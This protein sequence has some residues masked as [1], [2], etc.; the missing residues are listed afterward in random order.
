MKRGRSNNKLLLVCIFFIAF[1]GKTF[2]QCTSADSVF[3]SEFHYDNTGS[4]VNE[5]VEITGPA[6]T[7]LGCYRIIL[8]NGDNGQFYFTQTLSGFIDDEGCGYGSVP[9]FISGIQNGDPDGIVLYNSCSNTVIQF[10]SY[11]GTFTAVNGPASG[12]TSTDIG[13]YEGNTTPI[14]YSLQLTGTGRCYSDIV[15]TGGWV[16]P[17]TNS[18]GT[19]N[20]GLNMCLAPSSPDTLKFYL[21]STCIK[22]NKAA[23]ILVCAETYGGSTVTSY[24]GTITI[25]KISGP[26]SISG[27]L[28]Q[29]AVN[30][31]ATFSITFDQPGTY[32]LSASDGTLTGRSDNIVVEVPST[33]PKFTSILVNACGGSGT[34]EGINEYVTIQ[35]GVSDLNVN[36]I[37]ICFPNGGCFC[38]SG[39]GSQTWVSNPSFVA[40][41]NSTAGCPLFIDALS[42]GTIPAGATIV[43]FTGSSPTYNFDFSSRCGTG[44][45]YALFANNTNTSGR[46]LNYDPSCSTIRTLTAQ[47]GVCTDTVTYQPCQLSNTDGDMVL[48]DDA[49]NLTYTNYPGCDFILPVSEIKLFGYRENQLVHLYWQISQSLPLPSFFTIET[50]SS[51]STPP[52]PCSTI[53][54]IENQYDYDYQVFLPDA[55]PLYVRIKGKYLN[56]EVLYSNWIQLETNPNRLHLFPNPI[57]SRVSVAGPPFLKGTFLIATPTGEVLHGGSFES[58]SE[59]ENQ[60]NHILQS[61]N[62]GLYLLTLPESGLTYKLVKVR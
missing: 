40:Q 50:T 48:I 57:S 60:L 37:K 9:F 61:L 59:L 16:G 43:V 4:D 10:L 46:F 39:C 22:V 42:V 17:L 6:G 2:A 12:M 8:Y 58:V 32:V 15:S 26:G 24:N 38:N 29:N 13:V 18:A 23:T 27:T 34:P 20:S 44:P 25:A 31:C 36:S 62:D 55:S 28:T 3:I 56:G 11:E 7:N 41:L 5:F 54:S 35:N 45:Y 1:L 52:I 49:G 30:G 51:V 21:Q 19:L 33:Y 47:F 14:G 53:Q